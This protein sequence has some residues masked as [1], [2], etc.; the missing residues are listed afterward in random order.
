MLAVFM[1]SYVNLSCVTVGKDSSSS[2]E[3]RNCSDGHHYAP[4][5]VLRLFPFLLP[6][7]F[8]GQLL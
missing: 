4:F 5:A 3:Y 7:S 2:N 1:Y 8:F 6:R